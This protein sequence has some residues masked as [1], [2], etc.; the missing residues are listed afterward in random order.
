MP[1]SIQAT[2]TDASG[3]EFLLVRKQTSLE[4]QL[5]NLLYKVFDNGDFSEDSTFL[6]TDWLAHV[7]KEVLAKNFKT[8]MSAF[9]Q[10]PGKELYIFPARE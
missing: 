9:D 8:S 5:L 6:L 4:T 1:H 7:P 3:S 10:I 2:N